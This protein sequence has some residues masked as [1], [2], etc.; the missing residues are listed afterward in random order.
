MKSSYRHHL[1]EFV[2]LDL[3]I[4]WTPTSHTASKAEI[5][6][7]PAMY[8]TEYSHISQSWPVNAAVDQDV[9]KNREISID[10]DISE[11]GNCMK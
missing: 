2:N 4:K 6:A 9:Y 1:D 10:I 5:L 7:T 11:N 3:N 8:T